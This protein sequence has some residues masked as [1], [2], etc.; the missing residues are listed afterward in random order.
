MRAKRTD[1][2]HRDTAEEFRKAL[3]EATLYDA[4]GAGNGFPDFVVGWMG[5]NFL[6]ELKDPEKSPSRRS[7]TPAQE[8]FHGGWQGQIKIVHNAAEMCAEIARRAA[9]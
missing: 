3:P 4:S 1:D 9:K 5:R 8:I 6:F 2:N 7:L